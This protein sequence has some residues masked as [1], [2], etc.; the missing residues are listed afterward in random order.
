MNELRFLAN[1]WLV[2]W[3][4]GFETVYCSARQIVPRR[5]QLNPTK[6]ALR[7]LPR[8]S[9]IH[10]FGNKNKPPMYSRRFLCYFLNDARYESSASMR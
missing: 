5:G 7:K 10:L 3:P 8:E 4:Q 6:F 2:Q 9:D 1:E